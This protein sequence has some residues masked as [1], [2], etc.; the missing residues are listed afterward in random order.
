[1]IKIAIDKYPFWTS[2]KIGPN[3]FLERLSKSLKKLDCKLTSRFDPFYDIG[4]FAIKNKSFFKKPYV[5]RIGGIFFDEYNTIINTTDENNKIF[6]SINSSSGVVFV[7]EFTKTLVKK[8]YPSFNKENIVINN[9]V[10]LKEF[11]PLGENLREKF[12][13]NK[14]SFVIVVSAAWRRH[15]RL[16]ETIKFF[17]I[18]KNKFRNLKLLIIGEQKENYNDDD[19]FFA[20]KIKPENLPKYYRTGNLYLHLAWIEQNANTQVEALACG[21]PSICSNNGGNKETIINCNGGIVCETDS[22]YNFNLIDYYNP[23]E[24]NYENLIKS[25]NEI[26]MNYNIY[27]NQINFNPIDINLASEKYYDFL[28]KCANFY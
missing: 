1:M 28:K 13:F 22:E 20:G 25:F 5:I 3:I 4:L 15:K 27:K 18:L 10:C 12:G 14:K 11:T 6:N 21:L 7:S 17:K 24:P 16:K 8:F 23:P 2:L 9:S 26:Y 19:I